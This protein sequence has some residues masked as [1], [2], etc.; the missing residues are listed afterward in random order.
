MT[1]RTSMPPFSSLFPRL[2]PPPPG[3]SWLELQA[4]GIA[5]EQ[6]LWT[7]A[8]FVVQAIALVVTAAAVVA[9]WKAFRAAQ[10]QVALLRMDAHAAKVERIATLEKCLDCARSISMPGVAAERV[11]STPDDYAVFVI[12]TELPEITV[13]DLQ[14]AAILARQLGD[15]I[16]EPAR[17]VIAMSR[18]LQKAW[19]DVQERV[20]SVARVDQRDYQEYLLKSSVQSSRQIAHFRV[21]LALAAQAAGTLQPLLDAAALPQELVA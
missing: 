9:A 4:L 6:A 13:H 1:L 7:F 21:T 2:P 14:Q 10:L 5:R 12:G 3:A 8:A 18:A 16:L 17:H 20:D 19:S 15:Q 11:A